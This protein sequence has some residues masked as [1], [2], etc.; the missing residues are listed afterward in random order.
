MTAQLSAL[1]LAAGVWT[2]SDSRTR[3]AFTVGSIG[4]RPADGSVACSWGRLEVD[5]NGAPLRVCADLDLDS[6]D[7]G[8]VK[9]DADL[10]K[11]RFLDIDRHPTM[12]WSADRFARADDGSWTAEGVL[13]VRGTSAPLALVG[14]PGAAGPDGT[15]VRVRASGTLDRTAV[16][17]R[18]PSFLIGRTVRI[19]VDAWLTPVPR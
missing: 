17:I 8:I 18:A 5:G 15:W 6:L 13:A 2:V 10:R 16:G 4:G 14:G 12:R 7:T 9:R 11:P 19:D 1:P 3:V